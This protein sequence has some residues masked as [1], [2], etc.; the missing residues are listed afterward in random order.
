[1]DH[2]WWRGAKRGG[3]RGSDVL[4]LEVII[5]IVN[6]DWRVRLL[7]L[8]G[9]GMSATEVVGV[10]SGAWMVD[11]VNFLGINCCMDACSCI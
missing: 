5:A 1:M 8:E 9:G 11:I 2:G 10:Q 4:H 3:S 7:M 6:E